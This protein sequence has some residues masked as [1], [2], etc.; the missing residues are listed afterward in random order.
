MTSSDVG[1]PT[2]EVILVFFHVFQDL[3]EF[4]RH[5]NRPAQLKGHT[6]SD[7]NVANCRQDTEFKKS[8]RHLNFLKQLKK[9]TEMNSIESFSF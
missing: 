3:C 1:L 4:V 7:L 5:C 9:S 2:K 8:P 6:V